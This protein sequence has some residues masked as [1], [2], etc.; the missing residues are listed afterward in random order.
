MG[1]PSIKE[2]GKPMDASGKGKGKTLW[3]SQFKH[4]IK[5]WSITMILMED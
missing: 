5:N 4:I 2:L 3:K 1:N